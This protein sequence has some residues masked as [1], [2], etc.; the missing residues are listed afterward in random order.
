MIHFVYHDLDDLPKTEVSLRIS[1][2]DPYAVMR[3]SITFISWQRSQGDEALCESFL[4]FNEKSLVGNIRDYRLVTLELV[5]LDLH[6]I[7]QE[8]LGLD[9]LT[10]G[11]DAVS[12]SRRE[13]FG[14]A[15]ELPW[16]DFTLIFLFQDSCHYSMSDQVGVSPD[17]RGEV[18]VIPFC[19][20]VVSLRGSLVTG[21]FQASQE[22][23][24]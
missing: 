7:K 1:R 5:L 14:E 4:E 17:G 12:F 20:A 10:F 22:L 15:F 21:L 18:Q 19:Q 13:M 11:I 16:L 6:F 3:D 24:A 9:G 8:Q 23:Y 2:R